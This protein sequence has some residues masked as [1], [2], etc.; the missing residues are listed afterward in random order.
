MIRKATIKD[1]DSLLS[2]LQSVGNRYKD[3]SQGFL[4]EDYSQNQ[5]YYRQRYENE[6]KSLTYTYV[7]EDHDRVNAFLM[8]YTHEEWLNKY[9]DWVGQIHWHPGFDS[10]LLDKFILINQTAMY[11]ELTGKGIGSMLYENLIK[12]LKANEI[13]NIFAETIIAPIPNLASLNFRLKQKYA[14]AGTHY[15]E[16]EG[17]IYTTLVYYKPVSPQEKVVQFTAIHSKPF[18]RK[19]FAG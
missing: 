8:A 1:L 13:Q 10:R 18:D 15:E 12:D 7:N 6:I 16:N 19:E 5:R 11:P 4:M 2:I 9:P 14:I 17:I 3:P